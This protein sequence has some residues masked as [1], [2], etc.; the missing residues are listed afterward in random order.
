MAK[1]ALSCQ[2]LEWATGTPDTSVTT[3][4]F[5]FTVLDM[6]ADKMAFTVEPLEGKPF[7]I[8]F[9]G[10]AGVKLEKVNNLLIA[11]PPKNYFVGFSFPLSLKNLFVSLLRD[12]QRLVVCC[13]AKAAAPK[14]LMADYVSGTFALAKYVTVPLPEE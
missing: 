9:I 4:T 10:K 3:K 6:A 1:T 12:K 8:G 7:R 11:Y 5:T 13:H 2:L 14:T